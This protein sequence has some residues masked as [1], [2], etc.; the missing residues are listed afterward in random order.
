MHKFLL[1]G[2]FLLIFGGFSSAKKIVIPIDYPTI[3]VGIKN[4]QPGDTIF[5]KSGIYY[6][7]VVLVDGVALVGEDK[8]TTIIDGRRKGPTITA[9]DM[10]LIKNLTIRNGKIAGIICKN[11][12]PIIKEN[13]IV[14]NKGSGILAILALPEIKNNIIYDNTWSGIFCEGAK[15]LNTSIEHNVIIDNNYSGIHLENGSNVKISSNIFV[16]NYE[17]AIYA[18]ES[19]TKSKIVYNDIYNNYLSVNKYVVLDPTNISNDPKFIDPKTWNYFVKDVSAC[20]KAGEGTTDI[21]LIIEQEVVYTPSENDMDGDGILDKDDQCPNIPEDKDG[22]M[23]SDGC[24]DNDNDQDGIVDAQDKCPNEAEDIDSFEDQDGC[25]DPDN[26]KDGI[27][28]VADKCPNTPEN[29]NGYKDN[30]GCPDQKIAKI[31]KKMVF[32][33]INFEKASAKIMPES[34]PILDEIAEALKANPDVIIEIGGHTDSDGSRAANARLSLQR[35]N[36]V[37]EYLVKKGISPKRI[38]TRGYGEDFPIAD[39]STEEGKAKNRRIEIKRL[40]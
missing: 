36:A 12:A 8:V 24:P 26:D 16:G 38:K 15:S 4:A 34:Y 13:I 37:K 23:D 35:A 30:D 31:E 7:N 17:Y 10:A 29:F 9:A 20:K 21:G 33:N 14:D 39:N 18:D 1:I 19:S 3:E 22:Y 40:N 32:N 11:V 5:L 25:P 28:D 2:V 27:P 6:E